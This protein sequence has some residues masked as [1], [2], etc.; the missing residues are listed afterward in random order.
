MF[1]FKSGA[2]AG[3]QTSHWVHRLVPTGGTVEVSVTLSSG[4]GTGSLCYIG[5]LYLEKLREEIWR[6]GS[7]S[8]SCPQQGGDEADS[9]RG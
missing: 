7:G 5:A 6:G 3:Q 2:S 4:G 8:C 9:H 1:T